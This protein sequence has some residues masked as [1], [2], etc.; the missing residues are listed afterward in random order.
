MVSSQ[1][2]LL[3]TTARAAAAWVVSAEKNLVYAGH[4]NRAGAHRA[5]FERHHQRAALQP[6]PPQRRRRA[7]ERK[8]LGVR[9]RV[10]GRLPLVPCP[11]NDVPFVHH[12]RAD[13]HFARKL[14]LLRQRQRFAHPIP[15]RHPRSFPL[16]NSATVPGPE[17][18][19]MTGPTALRMIRSGSHPN[20]FTSV[21]FTTIASFSQSPWLMKII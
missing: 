9:R 21:S 13:R 8:Y 10:A 19:P 17:W 1:H 18:L 5:R 2:R 7:A 11:R 6:P 15:P 3:K 12:N 20:S 14:R 16:K 4:R